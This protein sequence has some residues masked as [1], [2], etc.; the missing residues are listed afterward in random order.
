MVPDTTQE[1]ITQV[2]HYDWLKVLDYDDAR[3]FRPSNYKR[4]IRQDFREY[5]QEFN[6]QIQK[7]E[8]NHNLLMYPAFLAKNST[9]AKVK[10]F[11]LKKM[12]KILWVYMWDEIDFPL[13]EILKPSYLNLRKNP[14]LLDSDNYPAALSGFHLWEKMLEYDKSMKKRNYTQA[15]YICIMELLRP[16]WT[17]II[18]KRYRILNTLINKDINKS[19]KKVKLS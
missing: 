14:D 11:W 12:Q 17:N 19:N 15:I 16:S 7:G 2:S 13:S 18:Q 6:A 1:Q 10:I 5:I 8:Y 9:D 4:M 3:V